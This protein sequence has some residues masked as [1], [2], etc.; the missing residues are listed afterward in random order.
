MQNQPVQDPN[1]NQINQKLIQQIQSYKASL[2][3]EGSKLRR[4]ER[5]GDQ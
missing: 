5:G 2:Q 3:Q 4:N 1:K